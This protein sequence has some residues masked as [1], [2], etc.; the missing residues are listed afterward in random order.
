MQI[1]IML[2]LNERI[3]AVQIQFTCF[4]LKVFKAQNHSKIEFLSNKF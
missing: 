3:T 1:E 4:K 2:H